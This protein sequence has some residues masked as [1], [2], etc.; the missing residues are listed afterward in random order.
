[1]PEAWIG[2]YRIASRLFTI[3]YQF[4]TPLQFP[5]LRSI[6]VLGNIE[7]LRSTR[8]DLATQCLPLVLLLPSW[9][10]P[11]SS[12]VS[13]APS[14]PLKFDL[15]TLFTT[16]LKFYRYVEH[17]SRPRA[18]KASEPLPLPFPGPRGFSLNSRRPLPP[19]P[20]PPLIT[21]VRR[22]STM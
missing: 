4:S 15:K 17:L 13:S 11:L 9:L 3:R 20:L 19:N 2:A 22:S 16:E 1:M 8:S 6:P 21:L 12:E 7:Q 5:S 14:L 10:S 18:S